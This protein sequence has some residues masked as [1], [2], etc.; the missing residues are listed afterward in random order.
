MSAQLQGKVVG[1]GVHPG[2]EPHG[3]SETPQ[4]VVDQLIHRSLEAKTHAY[5]PYS[6]F[7]VGAALLTHDDKV[8]T[9]RLDALV[10]FGVNLSFFRFCCDSDD[11]KRPQSS[12]QMET[13]LALLVH[14]ICVM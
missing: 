13:T 5:C 2:Q 4:E 8:F 1:D 3:S 11:L 9:G 12:Q 7:R 14:G 6:K 10:L